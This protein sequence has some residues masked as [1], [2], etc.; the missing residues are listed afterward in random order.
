MHA[1]APQC[2]CSR[3]SQK[4]IAAEGRR[5]HALRLLCLLFAPM[6][7]PTRATETASRRS[8]L[9]STR[10]RS[11]SVGLTGLRERRCTSHLL[12]TPPMPPS[13]GG[14]LP[15]APPQVGPSS[16]FTGFREEGGDYGRSPPCSPAPPAAVARTSL[17]HGARRCAPTDARE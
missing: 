14:R 6:G 5:P 9:R 7:S 17:D 10:F 16:I 15:C 8:S 4:K 11:W 12:R 2:R 13:P 1:T 3:L